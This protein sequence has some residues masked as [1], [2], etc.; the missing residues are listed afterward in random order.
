MLLCQ[1]TFIALTITLVCSVLFLIYFDKVVL[2]INWPFIR[3][4]W[5]ICVKGSSGSS[6]HYDSH[7]TLISLNWSK[8]SRR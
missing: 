3:I 8:A 5:I 2:N 6:S 4:Y 7:A 1:N